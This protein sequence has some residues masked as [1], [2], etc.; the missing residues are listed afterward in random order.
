MLLNMVRGQQR[1][2]A[3]FLS[4]HNASVGVEPRQF[5]KER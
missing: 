1:S 4:K 3:E 2:M 5:L